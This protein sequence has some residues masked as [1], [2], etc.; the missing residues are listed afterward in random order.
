MH[1][2]PNYVHFF[3]RSL[4]MI[5]KAEHTTGFTAGLVLCFA[6]EQ[7][8]G[9]V[10]RLEFLMAT[11]GIR[12]VEELRETI[13]L[14]EGRWICRPMQPL[15][16]APVRCTLPPLQAGLMLGLCG[17][18][19]YSPDRPLILTEARLARQLQLHRVDELPK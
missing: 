6:P 11:A 5:P 4:L 16:G 15:E 17:K 12:S 13:D 7:L 1:I 8:I 3:R 9:R 10:N 2:P 14:P 19:F 18:G